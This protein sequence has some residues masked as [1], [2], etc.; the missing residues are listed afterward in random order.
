M[1]RAGAPRS[2]EISAAARVL[3]RNPG[4]ATLDVREDYVALGQVVSGYRRSMVVKLMAGIILHGFYHR[5]ALECMAAALRLP[6]DRGLSGMEWTIAAQGGYDDMLNLGWEY[7]GPQ[8]FPYRWIK[9]GT[10]IAE[11]FR[12]HLSILYD[13]CVSIVSCPRPSICT[14]DSLLPKDLGWYSMSGTSRCMYMRRHL[15]RWMTCYLYPQGHPDAADWDLC[16]NGM[17]SGPPKAAALLNI[18]SYRRALVFRKAFSK[19]LGRGYS[20]YDLICFLCLAVVE[21]RKEV[22][23]SRW[24]VVSK[25]IHRRGDRYLVQLY[26]GQRSRYIGSCDSVLAAKKLY[27]RAVR[28][29]TP[30]VRR[31]SLKAKSG[32]GARMRGVYSFRDKY[33]AFLWRDGV[34]V[35]VGLYRTKA[36]AA[37][38]IRARQF[39]A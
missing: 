8:G 36:A 21:L 4:W 25:G 33:Q 24:P 29:G 39:D 15:A 23:A 30:G 17:G 38:A 31:V 11:S 1:P 13:A 7:H 20:I 19:A 28:S 27:A 22:A 5:A 14:I 9:S 6:S 34:R 2:V 26:D 35:Y 16:L 3:R 32:Q 37:A 18:D 12:P 10:K